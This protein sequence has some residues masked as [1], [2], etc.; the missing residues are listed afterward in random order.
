MLLSPN[1][2]RTV[3]KSSPRT[4]AFA[5]HR[6]VSCA[7]SNKEHLTP[8][9]AARPFST[10]RHEDDSR[11]EAPSKFKNAFGA[12]FDWEDPL[13][14]KSLL[15]DEEVRSLC[16][17]CVLYYSWWSVVINLNDGVPGRVTIISIFQV[18]EILWPE[19]FN[20]LFSG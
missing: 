19:C 17:T 11:N 12:Y 14:Y 10:A 18:G 7:K 9:T 16:N 20:T 3:L 13:N 2:T 8:L 5:V 4:T 1:L 6:I 15:T